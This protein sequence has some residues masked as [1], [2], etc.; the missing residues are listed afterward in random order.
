MK[1]WL[2]GLVGLLTLVGCD[3]ISNDGS[4]AL[5]KGV[6]TPDSAWTVTSAKDLGQTLPAV[7]AQASF[8]KPLTTTGRFV[9]VHYKFTPKKEKFVAVDSPVLVDEAGHE[10]QAITDDAYR[11]SGSQVFDIGPGTIGEFEPVYNVPKDA[12]KLR[13]KIVGK[14]TPG[15]PTLVNLKL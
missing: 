9:R 2:T 4:V 10:I 7:P 5:G 8:K 15:T 3:L 12:K 11:G 1:R 14:L 13:A 6:D